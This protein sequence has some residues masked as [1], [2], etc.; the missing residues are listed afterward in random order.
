MNAYAVFMMIAAFCGLLTS[1]SLQVFGLSLCL[2]TTAILLVGEVN[3]W[4]KK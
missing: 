2:L 4:W 3:R 1:S